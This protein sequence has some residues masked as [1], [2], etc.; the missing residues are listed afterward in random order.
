MTR[1]WRELRDARRK[2]KRDGKAGVPAIDDDALP[3]DLREILARAEERVQRLVQSWRQDDRGL[4]VELADLGQRGVAAD[5]RLADAE[6]QRDAA[7]ATDEA[8]KADE[9]E[10]LARLQEQLEELPTADAPAFS[11][12]EPE[13]PAP[14]PPVRTAGAATP[15][16][17]LVPQEPAPAGASEAWVASSIPEGAS[18]RGF[19]PLVYWPLIAL[20]VIGEIPLNAFAFRLFHESDLLTY[21]MTVTVA[22]GLVVGAH[23]LGLLASRPERT[24][25]ERVLIGVCILVPLGAITVISLVRYGYL[26]DVGGDTGVGP[27]LGTLAFGCMNLLVFG[28]AAGLSYLHHDPRTL[29]NRRAAV[30]AT[31]RERARV[32][33]RLAHEQRARLQR[34]YRVQDEARKR[35]EQARSRALAAEQERKRGALELQ[36]QRHRVELEAR[37][38][39]VLV[40][41]EQVAEAMRP[42]RDAARDRAD[43][44]AELNQLVEDARIALGEVEQRTQAIAVERRALWDSTNA[45]IREVRAHRDRLVFAYCSA[46]VRARA[47]HSSPRCFEDVP[48]LEIPVGFEA[49][50]SEVS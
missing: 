18:W 43:R 39:E 26:T 12:A 36:A 32:E 27:L 33:R 10:H 1:S 49:V 46:N 22:V 42:L 28:A 17:E 45:A 13:L 30:R 16:P 3:F 23:F 6:M 4:E 29:V 47:G 34:E 15:R 37:K 7:L 11:F 35:E 48:P 25:M 38:N 31:E 8:R 5:A 24:T 40:R 44:L 20:I 21:A 2:G 50:L 41:R 19:G 9:D 14:M